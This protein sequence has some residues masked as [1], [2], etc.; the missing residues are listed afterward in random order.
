M[1]SFMKRYEAQTYAATRVVV[2]FLFVS[3]GSQK[4]FG[5]PAEAPTQMPASMLYFVGGI[6]FFG[7]IL[8]MIGLFAGWAAF[9]CSGLMAA[10]YFMAHQG[11]GLL[12]IQN[13]GELA[14]LYSF[15]F[16]SIAVKGSGTWSI[17]ASRSG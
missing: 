6:E 1:A 7:G 3:H 2:G 8:V 10:A 4:L 15:V 17:D 13:H 5:F 14:A 9:L 16:L 12:P 11:S